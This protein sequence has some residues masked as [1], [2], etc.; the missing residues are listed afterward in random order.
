MERLPDS[1]AESQNILKQKLPGSVLETVQVP[2]RNQV[3]DAA[4]EKV[5]ADIEASTYTA[6]Q[7]TYMH[8]SLLLATSFSQ[9]T[10]HPVFLALFATG[11]LL[12]FC[13]FSCCTALGVQSCKCCVTFLMVYAACL[14]VCM[15]LTTIRCNQLVFAIR[16]IL[17]MLSGLGMEAMI[18]WVM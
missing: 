8:Q 14:P 15:S 11:D 17:G 9:S 12:C 4:L 18:P 7:N 16:G 2:E 1:D 3:S 6:N 10:W 5:K 13:H